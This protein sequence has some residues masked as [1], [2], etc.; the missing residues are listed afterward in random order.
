MAYNNDTLIRKGNT[1]QMIWNPE[2]IIIWLSKWMTLYPGDIVITG[3]PPRVRERLFL[4]GGD[5]YT[6]KIEGL[7]DLVTTFNDEKI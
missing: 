5:T 7:P 3:T 4:K 2:R 6:V 1:D